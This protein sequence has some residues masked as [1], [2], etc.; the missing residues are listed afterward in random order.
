MSIDIIIVDL[1]YNTLSVMILR[2]IYKRFKF[3]C[4]TIFISLKWHKKLFFFLKH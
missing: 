2:Y 4:H 1:L 3:G